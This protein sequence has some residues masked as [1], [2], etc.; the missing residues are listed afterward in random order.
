M[1]IRALDVANNAL[2][3]WVLQVMLRVHGFRWKS[4]Y[5]LV[6]CDPIYRVVLR[7][8]RIVV[9]HTADSGVYRTATSWTRIMMPLD[10]D[11]GGIQIHVHPSAWPPTA[12]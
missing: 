4:R 9:Y 10:P 5:G 11:G 12:E 1:Y 6:P 8:N 3:R 2:L 7:G